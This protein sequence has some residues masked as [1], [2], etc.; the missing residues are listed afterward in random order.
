MREVM[1]RRVA[2]RA[3]AAA[4]AAVRIHVPDA[5]ETPGW[6]RAPRRRSLAAQARRR[7]SSS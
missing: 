3:R 1:D 4:R 2:D 5:L 6:R 7:A